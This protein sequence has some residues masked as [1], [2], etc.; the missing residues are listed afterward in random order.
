MWQWFIINSN[1]F[2]CDWRPTTDESDVY[3]LVIVRKGIDPGMQGFFYTFPDATEFWT[4]DLFRKHP[5]LPDHWRYEGRADDIIV[6]SNGEKLNPVTIE[7]TVMG[8]PEVRGALVVGANRFQPALILEPRVYPSTKQ[9]KKEFIDSVWPTVAKANKATVGHGQISR[10]FIAISMPGKPFKR[11]GKGTIQR[12]TTIRMYEGYI[13]EIY[14][15]ADRVA[16]SDAVKLE[17]HTEDALIRSVMDVLRAAAVTVPLDPDIDFFQSGIDSMHVI[18]T[19]RMLRASLESTGIYVSPD[20]LATRVIYTH[21]TPRKLARYLFSLV[22]CEKDAMA[23]GAADE[24]VAMRRQI[25]RYTQDLP[26]RRGDKAMPSDENQTVLLTGST[27]ALGSYLLDFI[28]AE[29]GVRRVIC[30]NRSENGRERQMRVSAVR[31]L[32]T[33]FHKVEFLHADLGQDKLGLNDEADYDRLQNEVDRVIHSQ[34]PVN[35]NIAIES[36]EPHVRGVRRLIDFSAGARKAVPITFISSVGTLD[37]WKEPHAVPERQLDDLSLPSTGYGRSKLVSSLILDKATEVS[38]VPSEVIRVGQIAGPLGE[39]GAWN[40]QEWLPSIIASSLY[41]GALPGDLGIRDTVDWQ[42]IES[43][44]RTIL[45][46]AGVTEKLALEDVHGY[47]HGVNPRKTTWGALAPAVKAFYQGRIKRLLPFGHWIKLLE[48][49]Q[50]ATG[51]VSKNPAIKLLDTY[52]SWSVQDGQDV[53]H[54]DMETT[55]TER[56]SRTTRE[57]EAISPELMVHWCR[58]WGL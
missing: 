4:R 51:D 50:M 7:H 23:Y 3:E 31:G 56:Y 28:R 1:V 37:R 46:V 24:E 45:E 21:P 11:A 34:W 41:L 40:R 52:R 39:K 44:A 9:Q 8:H 35:F 14:N 42:P 47:F 17:F 49:S 10:Q 33:D 2:G 43:M 19:S 38:G 30:L 32:S 5:Q 27:G 55:R 57:L 13:D 6:L 12:S 29:P 54:I 22:K 20:A 15:N 25:E 18:N 58:Q 53:T 26:E 36:F 16:I 48:G